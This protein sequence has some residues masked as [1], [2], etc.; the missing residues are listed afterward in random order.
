M[1]IL[2]TNPNFEYTG[3]FPDGAEIHLTAELR[4]NPYQFSYMAEVMKDG[5]K[6][7]EMSGGMAKGLENV[8]RR[9]NSL[10]LKLAD[11]KVDKK[12]L[13][14]INEFFIKHIV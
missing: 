12:F 11:K 13:F 14:D 10:L 5:K 8:M 2:P 4:K 7:I 9:F 6:P 3:K 1:Q